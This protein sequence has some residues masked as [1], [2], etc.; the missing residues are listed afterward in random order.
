MMETRTIQE[1]LRLKL[2][3][4]KTMGVIAC[5]TLVILANEKRET[6]FRWPIFQC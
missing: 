4:Q 1:Q 5:N 3:V 6:T 2:I